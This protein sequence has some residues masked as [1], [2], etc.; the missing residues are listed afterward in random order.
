MDRLRAL[1]PQSP[2]HSA[3]FTAFAASV[4]CG[5]ALSGTDAETQ[6]AIDA[7]CAAPLPQLNNTAA[8]YLAFVS[9]Q[10][11][12]LRVVADA[13]PAGIL[14]PSCAGAELCDV[15][16]KGRDDDIYARHS[17]IW[18]RVA[19]GNCVLQMRVQQD[20]SGGCLRWVWVGCYF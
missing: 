17:D 14:P 3:E 19:R 2:F 18:R 20:V 8:A 9:S 10:P 4:G 6:A 11:R 15:R 12:L 1:R 16:V 13:V 5:A 7:A